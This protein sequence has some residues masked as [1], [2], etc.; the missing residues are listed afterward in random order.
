MQ[1]DEQANTGVRPF[2]VRNILAPTTLFSSPQAF[3]EKPATTE[4]AKDVTTREWSL[5]LCDLDVFLGGA[6]LQA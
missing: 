4:Y 1:L 2:M 5:I 6:V 3:I